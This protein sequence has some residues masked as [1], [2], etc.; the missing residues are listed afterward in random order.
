MKNNK[1]NPFTSK[2][3]CDYDK[4]RKADPNILNVLLSHLNPKSQKEK[5]LD[6]GCGTGNYTIAFHQRGYTVVGLDPSPSMLKRAREKCG[7]IVWIRDIAEQIP[8]LENEYAGVFSV[9]AV[10]HFDNLDEPFNQVYSILREGGKFVAFMPTTD[11]MEKFWISHY[12]PKTMEQWKT[13]KPSLANVKESLERTGF[14]N[15]SVERYIIRTDLIDCFANSSKHA[16]ERYLDQSFRN[17]MSTFFHEPIDDDVRRGCAML[18]GDIA[19]GEVGDII[20]KFENKNLGDYAVI[21]CSK[22]KSSS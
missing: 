20:S 5:Y 18:Y 4:T 19:S 7:E 16:P 14:S 17:G 21:V 8:F 10:H 6:L 13:N 12:F 1:E 22:L 11:Q 2:D 15:V 9:N 3:G